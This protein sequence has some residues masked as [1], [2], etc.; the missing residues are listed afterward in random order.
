M[1]LSLEG[2]QG[3][4]KTTVAVAIAYEEWLE[5][6]KQKKIISN[7]HLGFEY[8]HFD[9]A[10]FLEHLVDG[11]LENC[12]LILDEMYQIADSRSSATKINKLFTYFAVQT[13]K[14]DVDLYICTHHLDHIDLRLRRS[15][16][17]RG[18]CRYFPEIP[19]KACKGTKEVRGAPCERCKGWGEL[20]YCRVQFLD[21]RKRQRFTSAQLLGH[22]IFGPD[23]WSLFNTKERI[24]IQARILA[25]IDTAE[26]V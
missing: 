18:A 26:V 16:D 3:T 13:R 7:V 2:V 8:T 12:I 25:G 10:F 20:G 14:R 21:R 22:E 11:E 6:G 15:V 19:C 24:P 4:G 17:I 23:Y 5:S 9:L 1:I